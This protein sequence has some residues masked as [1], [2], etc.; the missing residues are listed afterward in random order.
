[1]EASA[2]H[3]PVRLDG[4]TRCQSCGER[5]A[6]GDVAAIDAISNTIVCFACATNRPEGE[7]GASAQR[8]Y[9]RRSQPRVWNVADPI[10]GETPTPRGKR[11]S[12]RTTF[13]A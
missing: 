5:L 3:A 11:S 2:R 8:E 1:M 7:A 6:A 12:A 13:R 9:E 4:D 10:A